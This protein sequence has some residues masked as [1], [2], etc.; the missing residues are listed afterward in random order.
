MTYILNIYIYIFI[1]IK[2]L[3]EPTYD[4][5]RCFVYYGNIK[6]KQHFWGCQNSFTT[7]SPE[8][9]AR[10]GGE[11]WSSGLRT[12][13]SLGEQKGWVTKKWR[14]L[15]GDPVGLL[16][17][18][19]EL[20][21]IYKIMHIY[22]YCMLFYVIVSSYILLYV[23]PYVIVCLSPDSFRCFNMLQSKADISTWNM[24]TKPGIAKSFLMA[25]NA[26]PHLVGV[27]HSYGP[28]NRAVN[29]MK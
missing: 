10:T 11:T 21:M 15:C 23:F 6:E 12:I 17:T 1:I 8:V 20:D 19:F 24:S 26:Q 29:G 28:T 2:I 25:I 22:S 9:F 5:I 27:P 13:Q 4:G 3:V 18:F 14:D 16:G 7:N